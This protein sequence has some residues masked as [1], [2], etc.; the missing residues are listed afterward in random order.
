MSNNNL[1]EI[2]LVYQQDNYDECILLFEMFNKDIELPNSIVFKYTPDFNYSEYQHDLQTIARGWS[3]NAELI[4][5]RDLKGYENQP[6]RILLT[7]NFFLLSK[8]EKYNIILHEFGHYFTNPE[9]LSIREYIAEKN[10]KILSA[11]NPT[12]SIKELLRQQNEALNY[13]FQMPKLVQEINAEL[14]VYNNFSDY[15]KLRLKVF[16]SDLN[17]YIT[18]FRNTTPDSFFLYQIPKLNFLL[19]WRKLII[20]QTNFSFTDDCLTQVSELFIL[21][22]KLA[23]KANI[24]NLEIIT[25]RRNLETALEYKFENIS[26]VK[27]LYESIFNDFIMH[28]VAFFPIGLQS[29]IKKFYG[30]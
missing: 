9:L 1:N 15:S 23:V 20:K 29:D 27:C 6:T 12:N 28:S 4:D 19:L 26:E 16:C 30:I 25:L 21:L 11:R 3:E 22:D 5:T 7:N 13:I 2:V 14:W 10:P 17:S 8:D 18:E 24:H